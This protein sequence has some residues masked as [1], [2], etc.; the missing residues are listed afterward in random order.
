M[1]TFHREFVKVGR[2][3]TKVVSYGGNVDSKPKKLVIIFPGNPGTFYLSIILK[4]SGSQTFGGWES[5]TKSCLVLKVY[6]RT[7]GY[8]CHQFLQHF[9]L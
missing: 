4:G 6:L 7:R 5:A 2:L 8:L 9:I 3:M 1:A